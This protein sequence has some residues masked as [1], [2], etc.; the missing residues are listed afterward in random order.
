[1]SERLSTARRVFHLLPNAH[2]D[3][4][5]LWDWRE[6]LNEG[7]IT[8]RTLLDLMDELPQLTFIRG[9]SCIYEHIEKNDPAT[10]KRIRC[11]VE[12]GRWDIV[13]GSYNQPD[14]NLA[15]TETLCRQY[16]RGMKYFKSRFGISPTVGWQADSFGHSPGLPNI[17]SSF[18]LESFAFSRPSRREFTM[19]EP[20]FWWEGGHQNKILCYRQYHDAYGTERD[21]LPKVLDYTLEQSALHPHRHVAVLVGLGNH[22]G[23]PSRRHVFDAEAWAAQHPEIELR[24]STL[25]GF[26]KELRRDIKKNAEAIPRFQGDMGF[27]LRGCYSSVMKFKSA[28]RRAEALV[29]EATITQAVISASVKSAPRSLEEA[30]DGILF[31]S[32]HDIL[33]GSSIERAFDE[34]FSWVGQSAH[35]AQSIRFQALNR[36]AEK[37][38]TVVPPPL[39]PDRATD[40]PLILW[41]PL[42]RPFKGLVELEASLDYRPI[43][44]HDASLGSLPLSLNTPE[45]EKIPFQEIKTEHNS[46]QFVAW[47]KRVVANIDLPP[48]GWQ[49]LHFGYRDEPVP[50]PQANPS[51]CRVFEG[52]M[53]TIQN[54]HWKIG[55]T[56]AGQLDIE[57]E[58]KRFFGANGFLGLSTFEDIWGSWGGMNEEPESY[59]VPVLRD[60]WIL[61][62]QAILETGPERASLWTRWKGGNSWVDLTFYLSRDSHEVRVKSRLLWNERSARLK[63]VLPCAGKVEMQV[64]ASKIERSQTGHLPMGRW[65]KR[66]EGPDTVSFVSDVLS[67]VDFT[68]DELRITLARASRYG[69][70]V[71]TRPDERSWQPATDCGE[72]KFEFWLAPGE[73]DLEKLSQ[74]LLHPPTV[75]AVPSRVGEKG[76]SGSL[77]SIEPECLAL[78]SADLEG[79][80]RKA[81][82]PGSESWGEAGHGSFTTGE[83]ENFVGEICD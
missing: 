25:H 6:G 76:S 38:D 53:P 52:K 35:Q 73:S 69:D 83:T 64:P 55:V 39:H 48:L 51:D 57:H 15:S 67:D 8:V 46:I 10:F 2:L 68:S 9:E 18:G 82:G 28:Y 45:G 66:G 58:G 14:T 75:L 80:K 41:N 4:V 32:F 74:E 11:M 5:W 31:N 22:G 79:K 54:G 17:F 19:P 72:L 44:G 77:A 21:N 29:E 43:W 34:Q 70:D 3:P 40:V 60:R 36:L 16:E 65:V 50:K 24:F 13:G 71:P 27:C 23:G 12:A 7:I 62:D 30:W 61:A 59:Q 78:L 49:V 33:P 1:M 63:L 47:R 42:P 37:I 20:A 56:K 26:F 81:I